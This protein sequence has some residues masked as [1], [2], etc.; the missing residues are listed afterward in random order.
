MER[1]IL[2]WKCHHHRPRVL[3]LQ[4]GWSSRCWFDFDLFWEFQSMASSNDLLSEFDQV[5]EFEMQMKQLI[6]QTT[7]SGSALQ[8]EGNAYGSGEVDCSPRFVNVLL[9]TAKFPRTQIQDL[10]T[11]ASLLTLDL[12]IDL[13]L[14][15]GGLRLLLAVVLETSNGVDVALP[16]LNVKF[17]AL[18]ATVTDTDRSSQNA[19]KGR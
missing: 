11:I 3:R 1:Q 13:L 8:G 14:A 5:R 18:A 4:I 15:S 7:C 2:M 17:R 12:E 9:S 16:M 10:E 19:E 6:F